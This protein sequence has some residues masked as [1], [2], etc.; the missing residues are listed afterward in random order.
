MYQVEV[1]FKGNKTTKVLRYET[2]EEAMK[3][4]DHF[5]DAAI[6]GDVLVLRHPKGSILSEYHPVDEDLRNE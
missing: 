6:G 4:W 2:R 3:S 1:T 5:T